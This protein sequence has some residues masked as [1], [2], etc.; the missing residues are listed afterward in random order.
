MNGPFEFKFLDDPRSGREKG[1]LEIRN[2][3]T[4]YRNFAGAPTKFTD[5]GRREFSIIIDD[6]LASILKE[7]GWNV[8]AYK[9][10]DGE[11]DLP[12]IKVKI[13][14]RDAKDERK[15]ALDPVVHVIKNGKMEELNETTVGMLDWATIDNV[16][17]RISPYHW[18]FNGSN[19]VSGYLKEIWVTLAVDELENLYVDCGSS[20]D[21]DCDK[22]AAH[23]MD[24]PFAMED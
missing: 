2:C 20:C 10:R 4:V 15:S 9:N 6:D 16:D 12:Y 18:N 7:D 14:Y 11:D 5:A 22:C 3:K 19:G 21:G 8:K 23:D 13:N 1:I 24:M 17:V